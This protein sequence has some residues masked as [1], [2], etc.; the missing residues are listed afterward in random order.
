MTD[1]VW[2]PSV[3]LPF[4]GVMSNRCVSCG[5]KFTGRDRGHEY[6]LHWRRTHEKDDPM[7]SEVLMEVT[8]EQAARIYEEVARG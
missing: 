7:A 1:T 3:P 8:R 2:I 6:E 5:A 4:L